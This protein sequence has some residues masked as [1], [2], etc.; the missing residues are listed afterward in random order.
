M[1]KTTQAFVGSGLKDVISADHLVAVDQHVLAHVLRLETR[2]LA[3]QRRQLFFQNIRHG[4]SPRLPDAAGAA[5]HAYP[6]F[7]PVR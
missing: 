5:K 4:H 7:L 1:T 6:I 2:A 3:L